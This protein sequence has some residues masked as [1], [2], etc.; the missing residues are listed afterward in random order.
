MFQ[1]TSQFSMFTRGYLSHLRPN[2]CWVLRPASR[3]LLEVPELIA[4]T[5]QPGTYSMAVFCRYPLV[6]TAI[7]AI[8]NWK[9]TR[10]C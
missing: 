4:K 1:T 2:P 9:I 5:R 6:M 7:A 10:L 8:A 3:A